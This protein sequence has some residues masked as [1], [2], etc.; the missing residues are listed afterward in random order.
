DG[1]PNTAHTKNPVPCILV[2]RNPV[3]GQT[4]RNGRLADVAPTLLHLLGV[5]APEVMTGES[6]V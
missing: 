2:Q 5:Q 6:L 3:P 1:T 4:L